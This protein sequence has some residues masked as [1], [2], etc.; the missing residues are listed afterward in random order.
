MPAARNASQAL[1][2]RLLRTRYGHPCEREGVPRF[3]PHGLRRL[4]VDRLYRDA[5]PGTA[6]AF[7]GHSEQSHG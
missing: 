7:L 4:A 2:L 6:A 1:P 5:D 3:T